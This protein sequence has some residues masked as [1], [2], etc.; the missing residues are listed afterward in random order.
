MTGA[1]TAFV[2][3][4]SPLTVTPAGASTALPALKDEAYTP[5]IGDRVAVIGF[6]TSKL[7]I[8]CKV[9]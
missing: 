6:D 3:T 1:R 8:V 9:G 5:T 7:L 2:T 4:T